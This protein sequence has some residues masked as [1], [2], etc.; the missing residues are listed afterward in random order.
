MEF[1]KFV[2]KPFLV[3]AVEVT[4]ENIAEIAPLVGVLKEKGDGTPFIQV[5]QRLVPNV[6]RV[7]PG[8]WV[9]RL[10]DTIRCYSKKAFFAQFA[11]GTEEVLNWVDS[12]NRPSETSAV[13]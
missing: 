7:Y 10:E 6:F 5:N 9:T 11:E 13:A 8:F 1:V 2:R 4:K 3:D 12:V